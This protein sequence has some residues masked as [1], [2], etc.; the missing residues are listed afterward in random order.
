MRKYSL[1]TSASEVAFGGGVQNI[2][3]SLKD[4][5]GAGVGAFRAAWIWEAKDGVHV[6][7]SSTLSAMTS[8]GCDSLALPTGRIM[9]KSSSPTDA[10]GFDSSAL[11]SLQTVEGSP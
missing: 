11:L 9:M 4:L 10:I 2:A 1:A 3:W 5:S 6:M 8:R 7:L